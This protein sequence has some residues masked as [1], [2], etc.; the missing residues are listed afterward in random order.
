MTPTNRRLVIV[1]L[2]ITNQIG[3]RYNEPQDTVNLAVK[4]QIWFIDMEGVL[5]SVFQHILMY[6]SST[7][8][9]FDQNNPKIQKKK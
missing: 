2:T 3:L 1:F 6:C 4:V 5:L 9:K 7:G 8:A